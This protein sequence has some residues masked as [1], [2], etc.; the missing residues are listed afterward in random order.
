MVLSF[1]FAINQTIIIETDPVVFMPTSIIT[2]QNLEQSGKFIF[3]HTCDN[4][5]D[6]SSPTFNIGDK[7]FISNGINSFSFDD[8]N[9]DSV[10]SYTTTLD[11]YLI[12][13][14]DKLN[15]H[16]NSL[17]GK[18]KRFDIDYLFSLNP[19][20]I[21]LDID[22]DA[23]IIT[24][25]NSYMNFDGGLTLTK[26]DVLGNTNIKQIEMSLPM[27]ITTYQVNT[28]DARNIA[29]RA[30]VIIDTLDYEYKLDV[31]NGISHNLQFTFIGAL[32]EILILDENNV[33]ENEKIEQTW[34]KFINYKTII[35]S[36]LILL[37]IGYFVFR[38]S[39]RFKNLF[40]KKNIN[41]NKK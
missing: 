12:V 32:I 39:K 9:Y 18:L 23:E 34:K 5:E 19:N 4:Y 30:Y 26:E 27:G 14:I 36:V 16:Y 25:N 29:V 37:T 24:I 11:D 17:T 2:H 1:Y 38:K 10:K 22:K 3:T 8:H 21:T 40:K 20:F 33:D 15:Y 7:I 41:I 28:T 35:I 13:K 31:G 6:F